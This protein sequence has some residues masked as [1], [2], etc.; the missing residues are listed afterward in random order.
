M[1]RVALSTERGWK[2]LRTDTLD[3]LKDGEAF[4]IH[5]L[6]EWIPQTAIPQLQQALLNFDRDGW[7]KEFKTKRKRSGPSDATRHM[8]ASIYNHILRK[9]K[10]TYLE[11]V[12]SRRLRRW[13]LSEAPRCLAR[14]ACRHLKTLNGRVAPCV[15]FAL[16]NTWMNGWTTA[17]RF[18][19][20]AAC[21]LCDGD[22]GADSI[23]HYSLCPVQ[24]EATRRLSRF[25]EKGSMVEFMCLTAV[26]SDQLCVR[27]AICFS[28]RKATNIRRADAVKGSFEQN[29]KLICRCHDVALAASQ[30]Y[31]TVYFGRT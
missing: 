2:R 25:H 28:V 20:T 14:R 29:V 23:E 30:K 8:Q 11:D 4:L 19:S 6:R 31:R 9:N 22:Y 24:R 12:L 17:R 3:S 16:L 13:Q 1:L 7:A 10:Q 18:Q 27:A 15:S 21:V 5:P 26:D